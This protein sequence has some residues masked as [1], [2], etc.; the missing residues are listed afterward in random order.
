M[1]AVYNQTVTVVEFEE[2][3]DGE[4]FFLYIFLAAL[5][6][7]LLV[8]GQH[9]LTSFSKKTSSRKQTIERGTGQSDDVDFE[10]LPKETLREI[11]R[12]QL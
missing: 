12:K 9:V 10:W 5:I 1:E 6:V 4:T 3:L 2:G 8:V 11:S 7:L